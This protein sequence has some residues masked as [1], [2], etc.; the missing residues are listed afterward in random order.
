MITVNQ[1]I[2][3]IALSFVLIFAVQRVFH[4]VS[5]DIASRKELIKGEGNAH[6][7][8]DFDEEQFADDIQDL[9]KARKARKNMHKNNN[10]ISKEDVVLR[11][12]LV[13]RDKG[14][15]STSFSAEIQHNNGTMPVGDIKTLRKMLGDFT[16]I[17]NEF[18]ASIEA[19]DGNF[20]SAL[21]TQVINKQTGEV[22]EEK[23][24][25]IPVGENPD[26]F[27]E[28]QAKQFAENSTKKH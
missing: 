3:L 17:I 15:P 12:E 10:R 4:T 7:L 5:K 1:A 24:T 2:V 16:D 9:N 13:L 11:F 27:I 28:S 25:D 19:G 21:V 8:L 22:V 23:I 26:D 6:D 18:E 20:T 14:T